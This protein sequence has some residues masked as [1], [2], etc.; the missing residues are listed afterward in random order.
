M[1][2]NRRVSSAPLPS[3]AFHK[4]VC[5]VSHPVSC[6]SF[7]GGTHHKFHSLP[8]SL[9]TAE[10]VLIFAWSII[11]SCHLEDLLIH[12]FRQ[13]PHSTLFL[14]LFCLWV[15]YFLMLSEKFDGIYVLKMHSGATNYLLVV[16]TA[17]WF[18]G[19]GSQL[20]TRC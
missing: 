9:V 10:P 15:I 8:A 7:L 11:Q 1:G 13:T 2:F 17:D 3:L 6:H 5:C 20:I 19:K 4:N 12:Y 16:I 18:L 14:F